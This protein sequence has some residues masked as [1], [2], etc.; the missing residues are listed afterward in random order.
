[1]SLRK[2][3]LFWFRRQGLSN[4]EHEN[5]R[6][7]HSN[8]LR[9]RLHF[10]FFYILFKTRVK[11]SFEIASVI[12]LFFIKKLSN[13]IESLLQF[14]IYMLQLTY[15]NS[16]V[17]EVCS[18]WCVKFFPGRISWNKKNINKNFGEVTTFAIEVYCENVFEE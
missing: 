17:F 11:V 8:S 13:I 10:V 9:P 4:A 7:S 15:T 3:S 12:F 1:M 14:S 16:I 5:I 6:K 2:K 18:G